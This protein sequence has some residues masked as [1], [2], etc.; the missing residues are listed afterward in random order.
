MQVG[1]RGRGA[2][3][4]REISPSVSQPYDDEHDCVGYC[5]EVAPGLFECAM[6]GLRYDTANLQDGGR[7][8]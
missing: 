1:G 8:G 5:V 2:E 7:H 3:G 6:C 4:S